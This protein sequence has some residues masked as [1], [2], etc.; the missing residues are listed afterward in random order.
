MSRRTLRAGLAASALLLLLSP[1]PALAQKTSGFPDIS[2]RSYKSG[3]AKVTVT[4]TFKMDAEIPIN[5]QASYSDGTMTW[6]QFGASGGDE[7]NSLI[8][9][10]DIREIGIQAGRGKVGAQGG[11]ME[12]EA[13]QCS[14]TVEVTKTEIVGDYKCVGVTS[15]EPGKGMG[16]VDMTVH[17]SAKS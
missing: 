5:A 7:P 2:Q 4:G 12:G 1:F 17:F 14:G 10:S 3:S 16:K 9:Y 13:S 15:Y 11:I 8:T 6:L